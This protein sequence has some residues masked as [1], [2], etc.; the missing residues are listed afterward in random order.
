MEQP[1]ARRAVWIVVAAGAVVLLA[2]LCRPGAD[3]NTELAR[4]ARDAVALAHDAQSDN[5][6]AVLWSERFR[7]L[8][9]V[10]GVSV[11]IVIVYLIWR[12]SSTSELD[13][14]EVLQG[15]E[16]YALPGP[17]SSPDP[18]LPTAPSQP[19]LSH[20]HDKPTN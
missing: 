3:P 16:E 10:A 8:G 4:T 1:Y 12:S 15:M 2:V 9:I 19:G 6:A 5:R 17:E 18:V 13:S 20:K 11:P 7:L 14:T